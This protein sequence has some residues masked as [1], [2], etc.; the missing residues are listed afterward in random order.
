MKQ[1]GFFGFLISV[2]I[3]SGCIKNNPEPAW[4]KIEKWTLEANP[5]LN[6]EEGVL[7]QNFTDAWVYVDEKLMGVFEVPVKIPILMSGN[8][9]IV[10][11]PAIRNI[12]VSDSKKI[13]PFC[14]GYEVYEDLVPGETVTIT[15][16]TRYASNVDFYYKEEFED[17]G[18]SIE[19]DNNVSNA[20]IVR[21]TNPDKVQY[22]SGCGFISLNNSS[23]SLW[24][25]FTNKQLVLPKQGAELFL[26]LDYMTTNQLMTGVLAI[27][28]NGVTQN[29]HVFL[30]P[31]QNGQ[32]VWKK[33]YLDLKEIVSNSTSAEYFEMYFR[34]II[35]AGDTDGEIYIDNLKIVHF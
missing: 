15:P 16:R 8:K 2:F 6:L 10:V 29:P 32:A 21:T 11:Y 31:S 13:Y 4:L 30:P 23:D 27:N 1:F 33:V 14:E 20:T 24:L 22:G 26:E 7:T 25:G 35:D 17:V 5:L 3:F 9:R 12:G 34:A 18:F 19:T 28:N